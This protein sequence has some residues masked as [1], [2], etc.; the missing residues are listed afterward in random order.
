MN[1][2]KKLINKYREL[3][4]YGIVGVLTTIVNIVI[5]A[6]FTRV[7]NLGLEIAEIIAWIGAVLFSFV[8]NKLVVFKSTNTTFSKTFKEFLEFVGARIASFG[9][10]LLILELG[11]RVFNLND[12]ICKCISEVFVIIINYYFSKYI[13][14]RK[15]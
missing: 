4:V 12:F 1:F 8:L 3:I 7:I 15:K 13:I 5:Y 6:L 14:F 9:V 2:I 11:V 10:E